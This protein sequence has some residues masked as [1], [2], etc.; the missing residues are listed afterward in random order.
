MRD[1]F[2]NG[3]PA[4]STCPKLTPFLNGKCT[5]RL[6]QGKLPWNKRE[7]LRDTMS[8]YAIYMYALGAPGSNHPCFK[9]PSCQCVPVSAFL[10][11]APYKPWHVLFNVLMRH[12]M[13]CLV[14]A[15]VSRM[16]LINPSLRA[17]CLNM[18]TNKS[19][20]TVR[21]SILFNTIKLG[22]VKMSPSNAQISVCSRS[23]CSRAGCKFWHGCSMTIVS[24]AVS[25][26]ASI[27]NTK[28]LQL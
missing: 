16:G 11:P 27:T 6:Y 15:E 4:S 22:L 2:S 14:R 24:R 25:A 10:L 19:G 12:W 26:D 8:R 17:S 28:T 3:T 13:P 1:P 20:H 18:D 5:T 21:Q 23:S 7:S 9:P